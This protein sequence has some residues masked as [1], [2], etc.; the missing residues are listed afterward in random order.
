[1]IVG[2]FI[3]RENALRVIVTSLLCFVWASAQAQEDGPDIGQD[4][5]ASQENTL[6]TEENNKNGTDVI[7]IR[8]TRKN[9][10]VD[11]R[12]YDVS[13]NADAASL[14][15][16]DAIARLPGVITDI[17]GNLSILGESDISYLVDGQYF[18]R[19][20]ALEIPAVQ[21]ERI[22]VV[23]NPGADSEGGGIVLNLILKKD[24]SA[25]KS[26]RLGLQADSRDRYKLSA[27]FNRDDN[28]WQNIVLLKAEDQRTVNSAN[29]DYVYLAPSEL[30][31]V[32]NAGSTNET[33][34]KSLLFFAL[35]NRK[36][37]GGRTVGGG[38][39][40]SYSGYRSEKDTRYERSSGGLPVQ[41]KNERSNY[42]PEFNSLSLSANY[43]REYA[44]DDN[45]N[46]SVNISRSHGERTRTSEAETNLGQSRFTREQESVRQS[47]RLE[48]KRQKKTDMGG[49]FKYGAN[50]KYETDENNYSVPVLTVADDVLAG[51]S[52]EATT[53]RMEFYV[54]RQF[55]RGGFVLLPGLRLDNFES[56]LVSGGS[57]LPHSP[58]FS[59]ILPSLHVSRDLKEFGTLRASVAVK[60]LR[61]DLTKFDPALRKTDYDRYRQGNPG[62]KI[63]KSSN[64]EMSHD[65]TG[66]HYALLTTLYHR[67]KEDG[68][69]TLYDYLGDDVYQLSFI[70]LEHENR[71]GINL[72]FKQSPFENFE[73]TLDM[74]Y[75]HLD[76]KWMDGGEVSELQQGAYDAK[77]NT[78]WKFGASDSVLLAVQYQGDQ[79]DI[80]GS[81]SGQLSS[82]IK[83][84]HDFEKNL[85]LTLEGIDLL[86]SDNSKSFFTTEEVEIRTVTE[87]ERRGFR[88]TL[89]RKF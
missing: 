16:E 22:E 34:Q 20:L 38:M 11:R 69:R 65:Y 48:F 30:G 21:I 6:L 33:R 44:Q 32:A 72:N 56:D 18:P 80:N 15:A 60:T 79:A 40:G 76:I 78:T 84:V 61:S 51:G 59:R 45:Y 86:A 2:N 19:S 58:S 75:Y 8:A 82:S 4:G 25:P 55:S 83:Y 63:G 64:Y 87:I 1:M 88:A 41:Q 54:S 70:N 49:E 17:E 74:N 67:R 42:E 77:L 26:L 39:A 13:T 5:K 85:T 43:V 81:R 68:T 35:T 89:S 46:F 53:R 71:S 31:Q 14:S 36:L 23:T 27:D 29:S 10:S 47:T 57:A 12:S 52:F 62:L 9:I 28:V 73:Y 66:K 37:P 3:G 50:L 7:T 24:F